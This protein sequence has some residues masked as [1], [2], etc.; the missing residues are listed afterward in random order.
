MGQIAPAVGAQITWSISCNRAGNIEGYPAIDDFVL[1][2]IRNSEGTF[3][4]PDFSRI[5]QL[6]DFQSVGD[7]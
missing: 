5:Q 3:G 2:T 6:Y 7:P 1:A 4:R